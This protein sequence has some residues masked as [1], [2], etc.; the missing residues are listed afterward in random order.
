MNHSDSHRPCRRGFTLIEALVVIGIVVALVAV[1]LPA[2]NRARK[3]AK[4]TA[5]QNQL[6]TIETA[7]VAYEQ[8]FK[9]FLPPGQLGGADS[10][11][12]AVMGITLVGPGGVPT[13]QPIDPAQ[14]GGGTG[15][16]AGPN[17]LPGDMVGVRIK[18]MIEYVCVVATNA[19]PPGANWRQ[20]SPNV[21]S[22][23]KNGPGL[24]TQDGKSWGP[25]IQPDKLKMRGAAILD[26]EGNPILYI[27][28]RK[29]KNNIHEPIPIP[30]ANGSSIGS[31]CAW[32]GDPQ[33]QP[34]YDAFFGWIPFV[35]LTQG[36]NLA[37]DRLKG[38][39][40][41]QVMLGAQPFDS[42]TKP[43]CINPEKTPVDEP[44]LLWS[45]GADGYYGPELSTDP[46]AQQRLVD[47]CDDVTNFR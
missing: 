37:S 23:G 16:A 5:I 38:V 19:R 28:A 22:D 27:P 18:T 15:Y 26:V 40:R 21:Y 10:I 6:R 7:F 46:A 1:L 12:F 11:G 14:G 43:G 34:Q 36:E 41:M 45:A 2:L 29:A 20:L 4:V 25:Y 30:G 13:T 3:S 32:S 39:K 42:Q 33:A 17:Y 35:R 47:K 44:Y 8:D 24:K 31:Y 9:G